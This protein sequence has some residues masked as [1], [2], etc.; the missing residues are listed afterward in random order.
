MNEFQN[1]LVMHTWTLDTTPLAAALRAIKNAGWN[2]VELRRV[3]FTRCF[4]AGMTNTQVIDLVRSS[5]AKV[6]LMGTEYGVLFTK[7]EERRRILNVL[8]DTCKNAV[9]LGCD[10]IMTATGPG[11][12]TVRDA[13]AG[14]REAGDIV[15]AHGLRLAYEFSAAH[16]WLNRLDVAREIMALVGHPNVGLLVDA[17]HFERSGAGGRGFEDVPAE[18]IFAFQYS[19]VPDTP[20]PAGA[21]PADR[22]L[23]GRG[24]VRWKEVFQLLV[25]KNYQGYL[26]YEA[27]N[28]E[29]WARPPEDVAR[30][31]LA[32]T[33]N[34]LAA[35][36]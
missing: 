9:A 13:A 25:E 7:G 30:E 6:G 29:T 22:L 1:R 16:D 34:L 26:S 31:A 8:E 15:K 18:E 24:T 33:R 23:P 21:R 10:M 28:P 35:A 19:D 11:E 20:L 12:G 17:Y 32:A 14:L 27:P 3:D 4:E 36:G 2:G 5:G